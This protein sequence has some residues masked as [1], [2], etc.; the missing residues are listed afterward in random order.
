M[1]NNIFL[2]PLFESRYKRFKKKFPS[3]EAEIQ[4]LQNELIKNPKLGVLITSD[5]YKIRVP[6]ADKN[7]GKSGGFRIITYL[8]EEKESGF[9]IN[10]ITIYDKSEESSINKETILKLI[11]KYLL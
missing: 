10:L 5:V 2:T 1:K 6:S 3:L 7:S 8:A 4:E 11:K 9:E